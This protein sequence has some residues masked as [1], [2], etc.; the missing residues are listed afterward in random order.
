MK[1]SDTDKMAKLIEW[2]KSE[3]DPKYRVFLIGGVPSQW[4]DLTGDSRDDVAWRGIYESLDGI[5]PWHVGRWRSVGSFKWYHDNRIAK[6]AK[7]CLELGILYM[8]TMCKCCADVV[9]ASVPYVQP[10]AE[11]CASFLQGPVFLGI[12]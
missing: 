11:A 12:T 7:L 2:F 4:R 1:V 10:I 8:P 6:D 9:L 3:A 5:H